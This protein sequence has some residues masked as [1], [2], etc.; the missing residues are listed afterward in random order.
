MSIKELSIQTYLRSGKTLDDLHNEFAIKSVIH[1]DGRVICNYSQIESPKTHPIV[2]ECRGLTLDRG[3]NWV[4]VGRAF[5]RFF[6][7]GEHAELTDTFDWSDFECYTKEDGS[8]TTLY[9]MGGQGW[10]VNTRGSFADSECNFSGKTWSE[11]F[12]ELLNNKDQWNQPNDLCHRYTYIFEFWTPYN[13]VVRIYDES[14]IILIGV[15][16]NVTGEDL[17]GAA[18]DIIAEAEG[19]RRP[20]CLKFKSLKEIEDFLEKQEEI[21]PTFEGVVVRDKNGLRMKIKSKTYVALHRLGSDGNLFNPKNILPFILAGEKDELFTYFPEVKETYYEVEAKVKA[22]FDQ[23]NQVFYEA[24]EIKE[25]KAFAIHITKKNPTP[26]AGLL[27]TL[28]KEFGTEIPDEWLER[29][30]RQSVTL[31]IKVLF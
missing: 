7:L 31:I 13:K 18:C 8:L 27:F 1:E 24:R 21:D 3:E 19:W 10:K 30:W 16:D 17:S 22:A 12:F 23:L 2:R 11:L 14:Q 20:T 4:V 15:R 29:T 9:S 28:R 6:N 26:F 5:D 25:Q